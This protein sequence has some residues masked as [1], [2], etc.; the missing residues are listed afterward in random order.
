[1]YKVDIDGNLSS[2]VTGFWSINTFQRSSVRRNVD[3]RNVAKYALS[4]LSLY[5]ITNQIF[6]IC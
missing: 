1:M 5:F 3:F 6:N 2:T 4:Y